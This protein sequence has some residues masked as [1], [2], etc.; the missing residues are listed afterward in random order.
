MMQYTLIKIPVK[1][2]L[3][4]TF[5]ITISKET[6][7]ERGYR[8]TQSP[9]LL[10]DQIERIRGTQVSH[11]R[12]IILVVAKKNPKQ[13]AALRKLLTDGFYYNGVHY[14]R[15][16]KSASQAKEGIT[17]FVCDEI[18]EELYAVTQMDI[19]VQSCI[20][21]KYEAQRCLL[22]SSCTPICDYMPNIVIIGEYE[23]TLRSQWIKYVSE[24][25]KEFTDPDS[26][27]TKPYTSREVKEGFRDLTI[28]PFDGC[29]C[30][31]RDFME[32]VSAQLGLDYNAAGVQVRLPFIKGYS[33]YVPFRKLLKEWGYTHITD[34]YGTA[35]KID[36]IDC[37]WNTSMFKGHAVFQ[38]TYGNDAWI[39][40]MQTLGKYRC[41]LGISKYSHHIKSLQKYT[42]MHFQYLQCLNLWNPRYIEC[43]EK[44]A[45]QDYDIL[46]PSND[47]PIIRLA[48]YTTDL[49]EKILQGDKFY[50]CKF[51]GITDTEPGS[52]Q[53]RYA[54][55]AM[56][57]DVMLEDPAVRR[58]LYRKL[59][60]AI[61]EA[62]IGK[63]YCSGFYHTG[64]GDMIGYLQ[65]AVGET[66]A[67]CLRERE[68]YSGNFDCGDIVSFRSP[69]VDPSEVNRA[70]I[71]ENDVLNR[72]FSHFKDQDIV[73]FNMY[74]ISAQQQGGADFDGDIFFLCNDPAVI[75]AK[76]EKPII[77][78]LNDKASAMPKPYTKENIVEYE[79][80]TRDSRIG[81]ITNAA[82]S[83]ENKYT[84]DVSLQKKYDDYASLLRV[85]Q[86]KE[87]DFLKTGFRWHMNSG[88]KKH[89]KQ[90]PYFLLYHYPDKMK[91]YQNLRE[92]N[93]SIEAKEDQL[94]Y[95][96]Y[97]SP[98][99]MNELCHYI[100]TWER[101]HILWNQPA[102]HLEEIRSLILNHDLDLSD[103]AILRTVR[104]TINAYAATLREQ[105]KL[106]WAHTNAYSMDAWIDQ[107]KERLASQLNSSEE[108]IAN[109]V[110]KASYNSLS[111]SKALA[112]TVYG[113]YILKN[114]NQ[115]TSAQQTLSITELP[116]QTK[117][118]Y[119]YLGTYYQME[120]G[121]NHHTLSV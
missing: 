81:E 118:S 106:G 60:K 11:L 87:I 49:F 119:E 45:L 40:Y 1:E 23:K 57:H 63:I 52:V 14:R 74:D 64:V 96:A 17:A 105:M 108:I 110:I 82:T 10:F 78:D 71:A 59:K 112:W 70:A 18:Y 16:G 75:H 84:K 93:K 100:C 86:G 48:R 27:E 12:E 73:M 24:T 47:G 44:K 95:N 114:L 98:S 42:R 89:I 117:D 33:V 20:I 99:P 25:Q 50:V 85:F 2:V 101:N 4:Q 83:I 97:H 88:L 91:T 107:W 37:I 32:T 55:A 103:K 7:I 5:D 66:P 69:L 22:F 26:G 109:Y 116:C 46:D 43:W 19:P 61:D 56:C 9:S 120:G 28:S 21:S 15:F 111:V 35:H 31:E 36:T 115:N 53:S 90:L 3:E 121:G 58:F 8:I 102:C 77:L 29:G 68:L 62:K 113:D 65:Y 67:G 104:R 34:I 80:M 41:K 79:I 38:E 6:E 39:R 94:P 30:H 92:K 54:T 72:W 13:E 76:I 51:L